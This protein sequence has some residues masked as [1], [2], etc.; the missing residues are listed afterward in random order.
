MNRTERSSTPCGV[1]CIVQR[2]HKNFVVPTLCKGGVTAT[3]AGVSSKA[4]L[5]GEKGGVRGFPG[6]FCVNSFR[7]ACTSFFEDK[8]LRISDE[9]VEGLHQYIESL[10]LVSI[11][12]NCAASRRFRGSKGRS[13]HLH[14]PARKICYGAMTPYA[15]PTHN[16]ISSLQSRV[17]TNQLVELNPSIGGTQPID[18]LNSQLTFATTTKNQDLRGCMQLFISLLRQEKTGMLVRNSVESPTRVQRA[19]TTSALRR[20]PFFSWLYMYVCIYHTCF[21]VCCIF[22]CFESRVVARVLLSLL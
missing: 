14:H 19:P 17:S 21:V 4:G 1:C 7:A 22:R 6:N 15:W 3:F 9:Q 20:W 13:T 16:P 5:V 12:W 18:W 11:C 10:L 8:L 2:L